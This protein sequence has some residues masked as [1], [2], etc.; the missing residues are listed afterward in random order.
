M[1]VSQL[2]LFYALHVD[3]CWS[4]HLSAHHLSHKSGWCPQKKKTSTLF[5]VTWVCLHSSWHHLCP[6][7]SDMYSISGELSSSHTSF[8]SIYPSLCCINELSENGFVWIYLL[9]STHFWRY[10]HWNSGFMTIIANGTNGDQTITVSLSSWFVSVFSDLYVDFQHIGIG[11]QKFLSLCISKAL[12]PN[13]YKTACQKLT[14]M[15]CL[16]A[17]RHC[18]ITCWSL[19]ILLCPLAVRMTKNDFELLQQEIREVGKH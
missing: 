14:N 4:S 2:Q 13:T 16:P 1:P 15:K 10:I 18:S 6:A 8:T 9:S 11:R 17:V 5:K 12:N 7:I 3:A 19:I